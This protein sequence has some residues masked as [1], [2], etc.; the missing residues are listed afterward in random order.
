M[1]NEMRAGQPRRLRGWSQAANIASRRLQGQ[2]RGA[3]GVIAQAKGA[4]RALVL[5]GGVCAGVSK[6]AGDLF[7]WRQR[8]P[9]G[10][11]YGDPLLPRAPT[12]AWA[13]RSRGSV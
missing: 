10:S 9:R 2:D 5:V 7:R 6:R 12:S 8:G 11:V 3:R 13:G 1:I 4:D